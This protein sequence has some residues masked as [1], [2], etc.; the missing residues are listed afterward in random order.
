MII[1]AENKKNHYLIKEFLSEVVFLNEN[2]NKVL[3]WK[4]V[5]DS[6]I[7]DAIT[8]SNKTNNLDKKTFAEDDIASDTMITN[9]IEKAP[10]YSGI[11]KYI[12]KGIITLGA[13]G[14]LWSAHKISSN[15]TTSD[16]KPSQSR[17]LESNKLENEALIHISNN[18][19]ANN[20]DIEN[21]KKVIKSKPQSE[22]EEIESEKKDEKEISL[23]KFKQSC[24]ERI[25]KFEGFKPFPYQDM[26]GVSIGYGTQFILSGDAGNL[27]ENWKDL[28]Y[29]KLGYSDSEIES[30]KSDKKHKK[31]IDK[32]LNSYKESQ[33]NLIKKLKSKRDKI[34]NPYKGNKKPKGWKPKYKFPKSERKRL[35]RIISNIQSRIDASNNRGIITT[36]EA[37]SLLV[38]DIELSIK[39]AQ[40][41]FGNTFFNMEEEVQLVLIDLYYNMGLYFLN[42]TYKNLKKALNEYKSEL[43]GDNNKEKIIELIE[44]IK[45]QISPSNAPL[46]HEQN[47]KRAKAN[48]NLLEDSIEN[49]KDSLKIESYSLKSS[50]KHLFS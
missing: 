39:K 48:N 6:D 16:P 30:L 44:K 36:S 14:L 24:K 23:S 41:D 5:T 31:S 7:F 4:P 3:G 50:C 33:Q 1:I 34:I 32:D 15:N 20:V 46:Y 13:L 47:S 22:G 17:E 45:N 11:S 29:K 27:E 9:F 18:S 19:N 40:K 37:E 35:S 38:K 8:S 43:E 25:K 21:I 49:L 28:I 2:D 12:K 10:E 26:N 42:T